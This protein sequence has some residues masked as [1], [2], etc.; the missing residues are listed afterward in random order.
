MLMEIVWV[1]SCTETQ[2]IRKFSLKEREEISEKKSTARFMNN[3]FT[4]V[5]GSI[6]KNQ[7]HFKSP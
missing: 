4:Q 5:E 2:R 3:V 7:K 6:S 1:V